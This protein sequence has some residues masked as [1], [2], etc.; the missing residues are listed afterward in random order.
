MLTAVA[1]F[2]CMDAL[3][4][5]LSQHYSPMQVAAMRGIASLPFMLLGIG[6]G[7]MGSFRDLRPVRF[8]MH[9]LR[10]A[11]TVIVMATF[12]YA[13]R[14]LS[15]ADAYS[16]FLA[17]PLIVTALS[18]PL[19]GEHVD[20]R[21]W[22]AIGVGMT[23]V[24]TMLR[25]SGSN[26]VT[27]GALSALASAAAYALNAITLRVV[28]RTE[29]TV[30]VAFWTVVCMTVFAAVFAAP[31][32]LPVAREHWLVLLGIG[33]FGAI[34]AQMLTEAFRSAPAS[35]VAP[36]EYTALL[37]GM[38]IDWI[39]WEVLPSTR[40]YVGGGLVIAS[41]LYLIWRERTLAAAA[42]TVRARG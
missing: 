40:V 34:G 6:L 20:W 4:K 42:E 35:V 25:P 33:L 22:A 12:V 21:R 10:G 7:L 9:V 27:L 16:I 5:I 8:R 32:W 15:L 24:L 2:A 18:V 19:L 1:A 37:W 26:L 29:T 31:G 3:L 17:A 36:F 30:S 41:G 38:C 39:V 13:V 23:G 11:L 14:V 28:T